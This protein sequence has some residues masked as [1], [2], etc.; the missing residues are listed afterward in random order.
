[1]SLICITADSVLLN[2]MK[3]EPHYEFNCFPQ[4]D[5]EQKPLIAINY[6]SLSEKLLC[7]CIYIFNNRNV[8]NIYLIKQINLSKHV[9]I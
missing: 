4:A 6:V 2:P 7:V 9:F 8:K 1:M 3:S 5:Y